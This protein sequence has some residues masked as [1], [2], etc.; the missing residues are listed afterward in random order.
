V[1]N[2]EVLDLEEATFF[3][4]HYSAMMRALLMSPLSMVRRP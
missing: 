3:P 2:L 4:T 1:L